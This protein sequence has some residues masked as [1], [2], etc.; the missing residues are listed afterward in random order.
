MFKK[1]HYLAAA[2]VLVL[3][4]NSSNAEDSLP[5]QL[6]P[7]EK[8]AGW[9][10]LFDGKS[11]NGWRRF[12]KQEAPGSGW[13][14]EDGIL[15]LSPGGKGGD[16]ITL[17]K[18][19]D[20]ELDWDWR[21]EPKANNGVKYLVSEDRP[22]SPGPEYQMVDD[23]TMQKDAHKT[24]GLYD[25]IAPPADKKL[26]PVGEWNHSKILVRGKHVEHWLNSKMTVTYELESSELKAAIAKSKFRNVADFDKKLTG[27]ILLTDHHDEAWFKNI[28]IRELKK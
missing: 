2:V 21:V 8:K 19:T 10:I 5:N 7:T 22:N 23:A 13:H 24:A 16:I 11:L 4:I 12:G 27:H 20:Y 3:T 6:T 25:I 18:F 15:K 14:V 28:K 9:K 26:N 1:I 17:E